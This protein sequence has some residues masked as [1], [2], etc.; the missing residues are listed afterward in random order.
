MTWMTAESRPLADEAGCRGNGIAGAA[1]SVHA[2][3]VTLVEKI[4]SFA[5]MSRGKRWLVGVSGGA[6]SVALLHLLVAAGFHNL[7][8]CHLDHRLRRRASTED[9]KFVKR[10]AESL[11][12]GCEIAAADVTG[13]MEKSNESMETTARNARHDFFS[14]CARKHR[15]RRVVLA[16]HADDQAETVLWNLLRGS[17]GFKGMRPEQK[18]KTES[19]TVLELHRPLLGIRRLEL[20]AWLVSEGHAW[21]EDASNAQPVAVRNRLR[22]E[23]LPLLAEIANRDVVP[24]FVRGAADTEDAEALETWALEQAKVMDPQGRLHLPVL[25]TLPVT[26]QRIALW[27]FLQDH[28]IGSLDRDLIE[29]GLGLIDVANPAV[30]NLPGGGR[31]RRR[32]GRLWLEC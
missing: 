10:L 3:A 9:A 5:G 25:R 18:L 15:C 27:K 21:R 20:V 16:H 24:A 8:V 7:V 29:R 1:G 22:N 14:E 26:L 12:V 6:D 23:V 31:L 13:L 17:K 11:G 4:P 2:A 28:G 32:A 19:G 30:V